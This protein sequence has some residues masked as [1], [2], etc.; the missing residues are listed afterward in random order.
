MARS[1][2]ILGI[3]MMLGT[4]CSVSSDAGLRPPDGNIQGSTKPTS[5]GSTSGANSTSSR[6]SSRA[7][8]QVSTTAGTAGRSGVS[9]SKSQ[10]TSATS[11]PSSTA[12]GTSSSAV[13]S[14]APG[15]SDA[16]SSGTGTSTDPRAC[17]HAPAHTCTQA[18]NCEV[19][20]RCGGLH[21]FDELGCQRADCDS[22]NECATGERCYRA[23]DFGDCASSNVDCFDLPDGSC[24]CV[25][26][27]DCAGSYC[28]PAS[29]YPG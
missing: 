3:S 22:D 29:E 12:V 27:D 14:S 4:G 15:S 8:G 9:S 24:E 20:G 25:V 11:R 13:S 26:T 23:L 18:M 2:W 10:P 6:T 17:G 19:R 1:A 7:G 28:V 21:R 5:S 16:K